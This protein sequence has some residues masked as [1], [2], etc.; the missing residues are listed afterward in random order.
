MIQLIL[1]LF[2]PR[3]HQP[4][5]GLHVEKVL[6][7]CSRPRSS[8]ATWRLDVHQRLHFAAI[9]RHFTAAHGGV[10]GFALQV[11]CPRCSHRMGRRFYRI[12]LYHDHGEDHKVH[13]V[14]L[15]ALDAGKGSISQVAQRARPL[16]APFIVFIQ[17]MCAFL[18]Q[19]TRAP[20][21]AILIV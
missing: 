21:I 18:Y 3:T 19:H 12:D 13:E 8:P 9:D 17:K 5:G 4:P 10:L 7:S 11:C 2:C 1:K 20:I 16:A 6:G 15:D 14:L